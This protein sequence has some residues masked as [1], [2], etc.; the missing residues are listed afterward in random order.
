MRYTTRTEYGIV[1]L[2]YMAR[3]FASGD[4]VTL[5]EIA[6]EEQFSV[7][8]VEKILQRLRGAGIVESH[9]G[10]HG[11]Y[12]LAKP[13]SEINLKQIIDALEGSTYDVFCE[14]HVREGIVCTHLSLCGLNG[15]WKKSKE[16]LDQL[17]SSITLDMLTQFGPRRDTTP[18][19][20]PMSA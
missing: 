2:I 17:Y 1:S 15:V 5:K 18:V 10:N 4:M 7:A 9:Q 11:G 8:F 6:K 3:H 19:R 20:E 16:L 12:S 14:P 13:P